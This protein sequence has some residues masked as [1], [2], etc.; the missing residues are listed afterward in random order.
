MKTVG[1]FFQAILLSTIGLNAY[2][3]GSA[4]YT[5]MKVYCMGVEL[6]GSQTLR[7][8]GVGRKR[9]DAKEQAKKNAVWA[10]IFTGI[11]E[12]VEGC[13]LR[14]LVTEVN[15]REKYEDYFNH[16]FK[17]DG[18]YKEFISMEDT[19]KRSTTKKKDKLGAT[20]SLTV[21]VLRPELKNK[22][23]ADNILK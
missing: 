10:V 22:L 23:K 19:K 4:T 2:S 11:R 13:N 8:E 16:F 14:P 7:V 20:Y 3:Q 5:D 9:G 1:K 18:P 17:D 6:D 12:G 21:R 15:A